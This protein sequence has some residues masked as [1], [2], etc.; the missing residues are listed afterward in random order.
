MTKRNDITALDEVAGNGLLSRRL[1]LR[2]GVAM[3]GAASQHDAAVGSRA[4]ERTLQVRRSIEEDNF[5][6]DL[7]ASKIKASCHDTMDTPLLAITT[8][9]NSAPAG[10]QKAS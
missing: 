4:A 8:L 3:A 2:G 5:L 1:L 10:T 6:R 9:D 7:Q